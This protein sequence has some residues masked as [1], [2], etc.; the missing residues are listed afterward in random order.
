MDY[1]YYE[2]VVFINVGGR[3]GIFEERSRI[4]ICEVCKLSFWDNVGLFIF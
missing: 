2:C 1:F 3:G 4:R